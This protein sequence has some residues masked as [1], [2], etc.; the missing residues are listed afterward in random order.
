MSRCFDSSAACWRANPTHQGNTRMV[1]GQLFSL[2]AATVIAF[3]A[4]SVCPAGLLVNGGFESPVLAPGGFSTIG[5]GGEPAG[6]GWTVAS[7]NVDVGHLPVVPFVLYSAHEGSQALD[8]NGTTRGSIFQDFATTIGQTYRLSFAYADNPF[9]TGVSTADVKVTDVGSAS[10]LIS[11]SISHSTSTNSPVPDADYFLFS[12]L[13]TATGLTTR[14][15]FT[16]TSA[17][18]SASGGIFLDAVDV[19]ESAVVPEPSSL[20]LLGIGLAGIAARRRRRRVA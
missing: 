3:A 7:G 18:G 6:F 16:S 5:V 15:S 17:N 11:T 12:R 20:A 4:A 14:L 13:F 9:A 1:K 19:S 8:L 2:M 10:D